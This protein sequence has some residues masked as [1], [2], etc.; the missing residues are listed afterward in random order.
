MF[1]SRVLVLNQNYEPLSVCSARRAVVLLCLEKA[2]MVERNHELVRSVSMTIPLPSIVRLSRFV[3]VPR[4]RILLNRRNVIKR[5]NHQCQYCGT[6]QQPLTLDHVIPKNRGGEDTW[7]NLVCACARCN[8]KKG[9][10]TP[11]EAGLVLKRQPRRP[12]YLMFIR[13]FVGI[14]DQRWCRY[15]FLDETALTSRYR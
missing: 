4:K 14:N 3:R 10:R 7:E 12:N 11:E 2:E 15:L 1:D 8:N 6:K 9:Q 13:H 5:D